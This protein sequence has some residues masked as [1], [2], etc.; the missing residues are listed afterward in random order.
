MFFSNVMICLFKFVFPSDILLFLM[1]FLIHNKANFKSSL[2][3]YE[4]NLTI[5]SYRNILVA[6]D[7]KI[8]TANFN[9]IFDLIL[10]LT[11][12]YV[13]GTTDKINNRILFIVLQ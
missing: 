2:Q 12:F 4:L 1:E 11:D 13:Y 10:Y 6:N 5:F 8:V 7:V 3:F 9:L